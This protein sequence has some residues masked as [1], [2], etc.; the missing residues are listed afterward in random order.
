MASSVISAHGADQESLVHVTTVEA[1]RQSKFRIA[2]ESGSLWGSVDP[3]ASM[4]G[5]NA[6][7]KTPNRR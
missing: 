5:A 3:M 4:G 2:S 7:I 6:K 1:A